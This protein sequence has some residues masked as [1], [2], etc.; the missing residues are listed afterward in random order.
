MITRHGR[1][2]V[3][4]KPVV[5]PAHAITQADLDWLAEHR[6]G[7]VAPAQGAGTLLTNLRDEEDSV[8]VYLDASV[9]VALL[10]VDAL[11]ARAD[12]FLRTNTPI[13]IVSDFAA[14]EFC[15]RRRTSRANW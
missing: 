7:R 4:V 1:L 15:F 6:I 9:L 12:A 14:A 2:V 5:K 13:M 8:S 11:T 3:L 10:I